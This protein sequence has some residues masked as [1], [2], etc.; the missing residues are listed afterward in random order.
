MRAWVRAASYTLSHP[1][2][3]VCA[4]QLQ[5]LP[6]YLSAYN[7]T[8]ASKRRGKWVEMQIISSGG[9]KDSRPGH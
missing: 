8:L 7:Q 6:S 5:S 9:N 1:N 2:S 4:Q 3:T